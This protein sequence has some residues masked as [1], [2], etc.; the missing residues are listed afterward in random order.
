MNEQTLSEK[1]VRAAIQEPDS[2]L[3]SQ[4]TREKLARLAYWRQQQKAKSKRDRALIRTAAKM[5]KER[6]IKPKPKRRPIE[7]CTIISIAGEPVEGLEDAYQD[8][9]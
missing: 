1:D 6:V 4:K 7:F 5:K 8:L 3:D 9:S 2:N